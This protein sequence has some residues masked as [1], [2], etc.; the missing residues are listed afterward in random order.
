MQ[1]NQFDWTT[2]LLQ[3]QKIQKEALCSSSKKAA[4][5]NPPDTMDDETTCRQL[6]MQ[7]KNANQKLNTVKALLSPHGLI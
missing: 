2:P 5:S 1:E 6:T 4:R 3:K 7:S